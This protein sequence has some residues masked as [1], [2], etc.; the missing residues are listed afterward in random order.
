[1]KIK[2]LSKAVLAM[3]MAAALCANTGVAYAA[4]ETCIFEDS[5]SDDADFIMEEYPEDE[6][7]SEEIYEEFPDPITEDES[8]ESEEEYSYEILEE[9][10][11]DSEWPSD[12]FEEDYFIDENDVS[13]N[14]V[15]GISA[16]KKEKP[17]KDVDI[18]TSGGTVIAVKP[19]K[20]IKDTVVLNAAVS[21]GGKVTWK[22]KNEGVADITTKGNEATIKAIK[23][24]KIT[25]TAISVE[26]PKNKAKLKIQVIQP[27]TEIQI[28]GKDEVYVGKKAQYE[29]HLTP[30]TASNKEVTWS[31]SEKTQIEGVS[32]GAT[33][34]KLTVKKT[35]GANQTITIVATAKDACGLSVEKKVKLIKDVDITASGNTTIATHAIGELKETVELTASVH[36][37]GDV[38]WKF[39]NKN[40]ADISYKGNKA[41]IKAKNPGTVIATAIEKNPDGTEHKA[42]IKIKV[43]TPPSKLSLTVPFDRMEDYVAMGCSLKFTPSFE[44]KYGKPTVKKIAW[45]YEVVGLD[46]KR[47]QKI[48]LSA[49]AQQKIKDKKYFFTFKKG[50]VKMV[51]EEAYEKQSKELWKENRSY[52]YAILVKASTTDG[53]NL[54]ASQLVMPIPG[55]NTMTIANNKRTV[56]EGQKNL[57][58]IYI[59]TNKG[60]KR[61]Y[62][63]YSKKGI[64]DAHVDGAGLV[65]VKGLKAGTTTVTIHSMDGT[66]VKATLKITVKK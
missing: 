4:E 64:A 22:F 55:N 61:V 8:V 2:G 41:T 28:T 58:F 29:A 47:E 36:S 63:T 1:M 43:I 34:G 52:H 17:V 56:W 24:G 18:T 6:E 49:D 37:G 57:D 9:L 62:I 38:S 45:D 7:L 14:D 66:G 11:E 21:H 3:V 26:N 44:N 15:V 51:G 39:E 59:H 54:T 12:E 23:P 46:N 33:T 25:A 40:V 13:D 5:I 32:I 31:I 48:N 60:L 19:F 53:S 50:T 35:V 65:W 27:V 16:E 42:K 30:K 20:G 10:T